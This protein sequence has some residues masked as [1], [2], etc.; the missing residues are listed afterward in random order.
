VQLDLH[1]VLAERLHRRVQL[2]LAL[3]DL[4]AGLAVSLSWMSLR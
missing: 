2:D 1:G 4:D 3:L